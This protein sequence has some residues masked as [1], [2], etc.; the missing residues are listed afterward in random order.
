[1]PKQPDVTFSFSIQLSPQMASTRGCTQQWGST[2]QRLGRWF[3]GTTRC[4]RGRGRGK[5]AQTKVIK[6]P[7]PITGTLDSLRLTAGEEALP[8]TGR[9]PPQPQD[10]ASLGRP[11]EGSGKEEGEQ[12]PTKPPAPKGWGTLR[13]PK[14]LHQPWALHKLSLLAFLTVT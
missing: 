7:F 10:R 3:K 13:S 11:K 2:G 9:S 14:C 8:R 6:Q 12:S 4:Y 5:P 1:M